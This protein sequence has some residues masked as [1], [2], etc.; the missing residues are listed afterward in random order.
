VYAAGDPPTPACFTMWGVFGAG[1]GHAV[2]SN[3][4]LQSPPDRFYGDRD[5][6]TNHSADKFTQRVHPNINAY[7]YP[8][9]PFY[10]SGHEKRDEG[11]KG[12]VQ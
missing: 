11:S 12:I 3:L 4:R 1:F 7:A 2:D 8:R 5:R 6:Q 9:G 10:K